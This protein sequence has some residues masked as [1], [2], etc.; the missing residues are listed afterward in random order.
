MVRSCRRLLST[1]PYFVRV[2]RV[3]VVFVC[4]AVLAGALCKDTCVSD[5]TDI[6]QVLMLTRTAAAPV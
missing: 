2:V 4:E 1:V 5:S 3:G 6:L